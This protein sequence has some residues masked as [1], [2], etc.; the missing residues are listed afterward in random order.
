MFYS[1]FLS[2]N[3]DFIMLKNIVLVRSVLHVL[4]LCANG[5]Y[6]RKSSWLEIAMIAP[7]VDG[8]TKC[9]SQHKSSITDENL[10]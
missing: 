3:Y 1:A 2:N 6:D 9:P 5:L 8:S 7:M 10:N 4:L